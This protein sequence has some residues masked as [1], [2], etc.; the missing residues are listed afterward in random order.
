[1]SATA[2]SGYHRVPMWASARKSGRI[3]RY[4]AFQKLVRR[5]RLVLQTS[6]VEIIVNTQGIAMA[7]EFRATSSLCSLMTLEVTKR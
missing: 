4:A 6:D 5:H 7:A 1:M 2:L 3:A